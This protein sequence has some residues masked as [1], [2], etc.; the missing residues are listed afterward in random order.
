[1]VADTL[2]YSR[3]ET[4]TRPLAPTDCAGPVVEALAN[5]HLSVEGSLAEVRVDPLPVVMANAPRLVQLFQN[6]I[7]NAIKYSGRTTPRVHISAERRDDDWVFSVRDNG[8]GIE[9]RHREQIFDMFQRVH[10]QN[11]YPGTGI[12]LAICKRVV[13][14]HRGRIWV[15]SEPGRGSAFYF[16]LPLRTGG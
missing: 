2:E 11:Q 10:A 4:R 8:I 6:L 16:S 5:L 14:Q 13:E 12:G 9:P 1:M 15:E 7:G 3:L